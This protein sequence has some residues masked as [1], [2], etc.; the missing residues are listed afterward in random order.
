MP[1][2]IIQAF[3]EATNGNTERV[4]KLVEPRCGDT[5]CAPFIF[6]DLLKSQAYLPCKLL[7]TH[8][9]QISKGFKPVADMEI[10]RMRPFSHKNLK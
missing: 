7:L 8:L 1:I 3:I 4:S 5:V 10:N 6:L 2:E 9:T